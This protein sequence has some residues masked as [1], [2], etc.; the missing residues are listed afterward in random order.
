MN[1]NM[2]HLEENGGKNLHGKDLKSARMSN[3]KLYFILI[4][5]I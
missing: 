5:N 4:K 1:Y 3:T 2:L